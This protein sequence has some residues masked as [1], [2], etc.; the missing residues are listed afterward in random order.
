ATTYSISVPLI[1]DADN[2]FVVTATDAAGNESPAADVPTI[3]QSTTAPTVTD[4]L[5]DTTV[6]ADTYTIQGTAVAGSTV[7]IYQDLNQDGGLDVNEPQVGPSQAVGGDGLFVI[8]VPRT[9]GTTTQD[10]GNYL[11]VTASNTAE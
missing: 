2:N 10:A 11:L 1:L 4:P 7:K 5:T 6:N 8:S 3:T 9:Q